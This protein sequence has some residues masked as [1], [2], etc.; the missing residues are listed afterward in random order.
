MEQLNTHQTHE[1]RVFGRSRPRSTSTQVEQGW[2]CSLRALARSLVPWLVCPQWVWATGTSPL[3]NTAVCIFMPQLKKKKKPPR[4]K[5]TKGTMLISQ[6]D[7]WSLGFTYLTPKFLHEAHGCSLSAHPLCI[8]MAFQSQLEDSTERA[9]SSWR[10]FHKE[11]VFLSSLLCAQKRLQ[12]HLPP[13]LNEELIP[14]ASPA[15]AV[16]LQLITQE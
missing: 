10:N 5:G 15:A 4:P 3:L 1:R 14:L 2:C 7:S 16:E 13:L 8:L 11:T 6:A 9:L 12:D